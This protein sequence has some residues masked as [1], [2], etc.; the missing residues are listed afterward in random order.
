MATD[1]FDGHR[2]VDDDAI[3]LL[4]AHAAQGIG[5]LGNLGQQFL[6]SDLGDFAVVGFKDD[7]DLVAETGFDV[8]VEAVVRNVQLAIGK[9]LEEGSIGFVKRPG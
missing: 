4:D 5:E 3:T 1:A 2:H 7:G 6:V 9:P 8:A